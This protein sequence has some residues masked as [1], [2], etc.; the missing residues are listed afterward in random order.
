[1]LFLLSVVVS[2]AQ[3]LHY[4]PHPI[5][6]VTPHIYS[7]FIMGVCIEQ[8]G[9]LLFGQLSVKLG[10]IPIRAGNSVF[11]AVMQ[12]ANLSNGSQIEADN[13]ELVS[14][15]IEEPM[16]DQEPPCDVAGG[17][18]W[19]SLDSQDNW[20]ALTIFHNYQLLSFLEGQEQI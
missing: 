2:E 11:A 8:E 10:V 14:Q 13:W 9:R 4:Y 7:K 12:Q 20:K 1:M 17:P 16:D 15:A 18:L 3:V 5:Q 19:H 6:D